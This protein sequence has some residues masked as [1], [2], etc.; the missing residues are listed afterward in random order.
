[1]YKGNKNLLP[2]SS[3]HKHTRRNNEI[4][5]LNYLTEVHSS[6]TDEKTVILGEMA[7]N[8]IIESNQ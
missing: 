8:R 2:H 3:Q 4:I 5:I 1:M 6:G 7:I